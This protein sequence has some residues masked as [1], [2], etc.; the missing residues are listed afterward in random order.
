MTNRRKLIVMLGASAFATPVASFAQKK[1]EK[2]YRIGVI[3]GGTAVANLH[4]QEPLKQG[5]RE[6]G[7]RQSDRHH[8]P[9]DHPGAGGPSD[10][11]TTRR[12]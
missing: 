7:Y 2:V 11:V 3:F 5:L 8:D 9:A 12:E 1:P 10:R 4:L 6:V